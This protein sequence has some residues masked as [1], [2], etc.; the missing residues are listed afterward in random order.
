MSRPRHDALTVF[1]FG[2]LFGGNSL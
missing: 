2:E 1:K